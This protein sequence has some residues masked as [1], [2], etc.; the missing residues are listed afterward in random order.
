MV[1]TP[2][3]AERSADRWLGVLFGCAFP[4]ATAIAFA[5]YALEPGLL[6]AES[7]QWGALL[8]LA[9]IPLCLLGAVFAGVAA[10]PGPAWRRMAIYLV[11]LGLLI[12][13]TGWWEIV[14]DDSMGPLLGWAVASHLLSLIW[15]G[16]NPEL[17]AARADAIGSDAASMIPL[18]GWS[19][20]LA[21]AAIVAYTQIFTGDFEHGPW[22][23]LAWVGAA[24]FAIRARSIVHAYSRSFDV[25]R[26][27]YLD[28]PWVHRLTSKPASSEASPD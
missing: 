1:A 12:V 28:R 18:T 13:A 24:H 27:A 22:N 15:L 23:Q 7:G 16:P 6:P 17:A 2:P 14:K 20:V 4:L 10:I 9:E 5:L 8:L 19:L 25:T 21:A 11:A 26:K 3:V